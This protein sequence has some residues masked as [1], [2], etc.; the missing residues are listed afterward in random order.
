LKR[1]S[2]YCRLP[3]SAAFPDGLPPQFGELIETAE[4]PKHLGDELFK[5]TGVPFDRPMKRGPESLQFAFPAC[6]SPIAFMGS[7]APVAVTMP[8]I[9]RFP[10]QPKVFGRK[11]SLAGAT[12][13]AVSLLNGFHP[14]NYPPASDGG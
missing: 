13:A 11:L 7:V 5:R 8:S 2:R 1:P 12:N 4:S 3:I 10:P 6:R 14:W 9:R